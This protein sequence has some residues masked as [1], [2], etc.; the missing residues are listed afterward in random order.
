MRPFLTLLLLLLV[1][2]PSGAA[3]PETPVPAQGRVVDVYDG[4]TLTLASGD[5]IR[6]RW[7]N[8]PELRPK[9]DYGIEAREAA[10]SL[11]LGRMVTLKPG[12]VARDGYGRIIA[13]IEVDGIDLSTHLL[14][15]GLAHLFLIPPDD[16]NHD[17]RREAQTKARLAGRGIWSTDRYRGVLHIT[18]FHANADGDDRANVN[19]EY[20]RIANVSDRPV[21]LDGFRIAEQAGRSWVLPAM[22]IPPGHT[23]KLHSG[24]GDNQSD[25]QRQLAVFLNS[26]VPIWNNTRDRATVYDRHGRVVDSRLHAPKNPSR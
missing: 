12:P 4:D 2:P 24:N 5:K 26:D 17:E 18:S 15:L 3:A 14:S 25:P 13:G 22:L 21:D 1:T 16:A 8:T 10:R 6:L 20:L 11:V 9:E 23:F 19:G 7:V